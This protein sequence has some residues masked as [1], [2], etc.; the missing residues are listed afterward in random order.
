MQHPLVRPSL[1]P[2]G[3]AYPNQV[4]RLDYKSPFDK[5][6]VNP[7][8]VMAKFWAARH[9]LDMPRPWPVETIIHNILP[10]MAKANE[11]TERDFEFGGLPFLGR[12]IAVL[13]TV[14]YWL[15]TNCGGAFL[16]PTPKW[17]SEDRRLPHLDYGPRPPSER[18]FLEKF[19]KDMERRDMVV[20]WI[21]T[22]VQECTEPVPV[23]A[24][25]HCYDASE[26]RSRDYA[27]VEGLMRWLG[28]KEGREFITDYEAKLKRSR[29][30]AD[31]GRLAESQAARIAA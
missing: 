25:P 29:T 11:L 19:R 7:E 13:S 28:R 23:L 14:V 6:W 9:R 3:F 17:V 27:L 16:H 21:H 24:D 2:Y 18:D 12:D 30:A 26:V 8:R 1:A 15:G 4:K 5:H 20:F 22:C 31:Q 10:G